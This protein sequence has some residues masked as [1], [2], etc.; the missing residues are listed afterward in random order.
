[1]AIPLE[2]EK[3]FR[4]SWSLQTKSAHGRIRPEVAHM[5]E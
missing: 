5:K 2:M 1:M 4:N 3:F